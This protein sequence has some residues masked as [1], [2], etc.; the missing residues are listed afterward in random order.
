MAD[1]VSLAQAGFRVEYYFFY[2][3]LMDRTVLARVLQKHHRPEIYPAS[4]KGWQRKMWGEYPALDHSPGYTTKGT[5][6]EVRSSRERDRL[7]GYETDA[8]KVQPCLIDVGHG[9]SVQGKTF[10]WDDDP[11]L[12]RY[13]T[14]DLKDWLLKQKEFEIQQFH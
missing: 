5:A 13:G 12:L 4:L 10:V 2:G 9:H 14:F 1:T 6:Y 3:S 11:E 8:Y 7:I